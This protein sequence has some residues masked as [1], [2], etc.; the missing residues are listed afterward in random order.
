M[1][2]LSALPKNL[3]KMFDDDAVASLCKL[4]G[5]SIQETTYVTAMTLGNLAHCPGREKR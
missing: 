5:S 4:L 2:T 3:E 1:C